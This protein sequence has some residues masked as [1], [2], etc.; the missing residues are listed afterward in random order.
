MS[1]P[2]PIEP[3]I[4]SFQCICG[5][6]SYALD[7]DLKGCR[8]PGESHWYTRMKTPGHCGRCGRP[9]GAPYPKDW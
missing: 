9:H 6:I 7:S 8:F 1:Q 4:I 5:V 3:T 2:L